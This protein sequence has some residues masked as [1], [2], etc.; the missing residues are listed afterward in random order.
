MRRMMRVHGSW[1]IGLAAMAACTP[2]DGSSGVESKDS[3]TQPAPGGDGGNSGTSN[4]GGGGADAG[5]DGSSTRDAGDFCAGAKLC[6]RFERSTPLG[7]PWTELDT[8]TSGASLTI[9]TGQLGLALR[10]EVP[11][12]ATEQVGKAFLIVEPLKL[13]R[14]VTLA[15]SIRVE[16]PSHGFGDQ[17]ELLTLSCSNGMAIFGRFGLSFNSAGISALGR[18]DGQPPFDVQIATFD[19]W[20]TYELTLSQDAKLDVSVDGSLLA[21]SNTVFTG[22][23]A[24]AACGLRIGLQATGTHPRLVAHFDDLRLR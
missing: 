18:R 2:F 9:G 19:A 4:D 15:V 20:H 11:A 8:P 10:A 23:D 17:A 5:S 24:D 22:F 6:D 7:A 14:P 16:A 3:G 1:A 13:E 21:S 12:V